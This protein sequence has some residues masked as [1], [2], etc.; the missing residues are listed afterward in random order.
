MNDTF[1]IVYADLKDSW[2]KGN[3][4]EALAKGYLAPHVII[5]KTI[6]DFLKTDSGLSDDESVNLERIILAGEKAG[7]KKMRIKI[8]KK[9]LTGANGALSRLM[10]NSKLKMIIGKESDSSYFIDVEYK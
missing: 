2:N 10:K 3:R 4:F 8:D 5:L 1:E 6:Q 7:A 9:E